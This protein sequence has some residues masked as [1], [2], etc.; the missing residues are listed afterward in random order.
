MTFGETLEWQRVNSVHIKRLADLGDRLA[1][2]L[3]TAY[4][5]LYADQLNPIKQNEWMKI[6]DDYCRR[7]LTIVTRVLLQDRFGHKA[8]KTLRRLDS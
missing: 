7:D 8:P 2:K 3:I 1:M 6:A 5:E 4:R